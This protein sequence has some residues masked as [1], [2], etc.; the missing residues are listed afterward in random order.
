MRSVGMLWSVL[1]LTL[2][3]ILPS[4]VLCGKC[5]DCTTVVAGLQEAS[6]SN[7]SISMQQGMIINMICPDADLG[8]P[9]DHPNCEK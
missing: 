1:Y 7:L 2:T 9:D 4:T 6:L 8:A 3:L 5:D